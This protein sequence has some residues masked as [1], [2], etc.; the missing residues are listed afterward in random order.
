MKEKYLFFQNAANDCNV[1][2][3]SKLI[4]VEAGD[5][6]LNMTFD[7]IAGEDLIVLTVTA[8][9]HQV[10]VDLATALGGPVHSDGVIMVADDAN[11]KYII[12]AVTGVATGA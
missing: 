7:T 12:P 9:E 2:P 5:A 8:N 4:N 6:V 3:L 10:M 1:Y 11:S